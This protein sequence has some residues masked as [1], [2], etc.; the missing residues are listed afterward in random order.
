MLTAS[1]KYTPFTD[2]D[3]IN[4]L[5]YYPV[6]CYVEEETIV[7]VMRTPLLIWLEEQISYDAY[8]FKKKDIE[9]GIRKLRDISN[10]K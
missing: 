10:E 4:G 3:W 2:P 8:R 9:E 6:R 5:E 1:G 7:M